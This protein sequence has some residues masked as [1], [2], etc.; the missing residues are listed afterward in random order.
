M[1][2]ASG[3]G[4]M[5][6]ASGVGEMSGGTGRDGAPFTGPVSRA[7]VVARIEA[8]PLGDTSEEMRRG[9]EAL[10][11]PA[12][13]DALFGCRLGGGG[14]VAGTMVL[15]PEGEAPASP[16]RIVYLHGGGYVFGGPRTHA[17]LA[18]GLVARTGWPAF[19]PRYP[20]APE[21][22][23]PA[24]LDAACAA[25]RSLEANGRVV[26]AGDSAG[27]H[28]ALVTALALARAGNPVDGLVL[29]SPN[30]DRSGLSDT[31]GRNDALDPMVDD[32][33]DRALARMCFGDMALDHPEVSPVLDDLSL[34]PPLYVEAGDEEVLLGDT[35]VLAE[36]ARAAGVD[37]TLHVEP[38]GLHMGQM[39]AP[40]WPVAAASLDR[41]A[42][43][44]RGL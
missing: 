37:V 14:A 39:W 32:A 13:N 22:P 33:G 25:V 21:H 36:R 18:A 35:L 1:S 38:E 2:D 16:D 9:F 8:R 23:W 4:A 15:P 26:V 43:F 6:D 5:S 30:T 7:E 28:L 34:L 41:A 11:A 42:A 29:F 20:L 27:G 24:A 19:L 44:V 3:V 31:R 10:V 17:R 12:A 40:W